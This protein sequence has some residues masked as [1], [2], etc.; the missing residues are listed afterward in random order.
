VTLIFTT[1]YDDF[2]KSV[3][4]FL[5]QESPESRVRAVMSSPEESDTQTWQALQRTYEVARIGV[6]PEFGGVGP[7]VLQAAVISEELGRSLACVPFLGSTVLAGTALRASENVGI[8]RGALPQLAE[9][10][11]VACLALAEDAGRW[12]VGKCATVAEP[13][14]DG[15]VIDGSKSFVLDGYQAD[16]VLVVAAMSGRPA[17]FLVDGHASGLSRTLL[18]TLDQTRKLAR[19]TFSQVPARLVCSGDSTVSAIETAMA[20]S[21][22]MLT[23]E[24]V[25]GAERLLEMSVSYAKL[26]VQFGRPI[27]SFQAIKHKCA[28]MLVAVTNARAAAYSVVEE[29]EATGRVSA[30]RMGAAK[31]YCSDAYK[32]VAEATIQVHGGI[33]FTWEHSAHLYLKRAVASAELFGSAEMHREIVGRELGI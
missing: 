9:A 3:R 30:V 11:S 12:D 1:Q 19:L 5:D 7:A 23:L 27:G 15:F 4:G 20:T 8:Q 29:L 24:Q 28:D 21:K 32:Q 22:V 25:G 17:L 26:R 13:G 10:E 16:V 18:P 14:A 2:R 31:A 6:P 33:G